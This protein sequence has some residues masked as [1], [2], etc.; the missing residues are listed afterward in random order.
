MKIYHTIN[1]I[2]INMMENEHGTTSNEATQTELRLNKVY[3]DE[4][5]LV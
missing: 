5:E 2:L 3:K 4:E 1:V